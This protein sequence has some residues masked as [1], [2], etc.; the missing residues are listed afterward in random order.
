[1]TLNRRRANGG[2]LTH[3][4]PDGQY[5]ALC[6]FSPQPSR[7]AHIVHRRIGW[8]FANEE[9]QYLCA[10]CHE[11]EADMRLISPSPA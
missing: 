7:K 8:H 4:V 3:L 1:M 2:H 5:V 9:S 10:R 11:I 6:G